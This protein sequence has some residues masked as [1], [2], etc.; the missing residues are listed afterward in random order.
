MIIS[1][2][3]HNDFEVLGECD[4]CGRPL[5]RGELILTDELGTYCSTQCQQ[6]VHGA[7]VIEIASRIIT[8]GKRCHARSRSER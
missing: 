4:N 6:Y 8:G 7:V 1:G 2:G 3:T 5:F